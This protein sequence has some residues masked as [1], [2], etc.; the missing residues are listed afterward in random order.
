MLS[1]THAKH[2]TVTRL[3]RFALFPHPHRAPRGMHG[4]EKTEQENVVT[5]AS[6]SAGIKE[7]VTIV[8][9]EG[10]RVVYATA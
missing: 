8:A 7:V 1:R 4:D 10:I 9:G 2:V 3:P 5:S 6:L